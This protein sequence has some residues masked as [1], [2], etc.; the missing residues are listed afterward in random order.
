MKVFVVHYKKLTE[1]KTHILE[2]FFKHNITDYE[3]IEIDR[4]ELH[5]HDTSMFAEH[6]NQSSRAI[7]LSHF[8]AYKHIIM[9]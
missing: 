2:Q 8:Y 5:E 4:D 3:F 7:T 9:V 6:Y 1:R